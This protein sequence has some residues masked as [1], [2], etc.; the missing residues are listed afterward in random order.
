MT[1]AAKLDSVTV[2]WF[3]PGPTI[4][5]Y[6]ASTALVQAVMGP[7]GGGKTSS[8]FIKA[9]VLAQQQRRSTRDGVRRFKL[10]MVHKTYR[11]LWASIIPSWWKWM[12]KTAGEWTG[13]QDQPATHRINFALPDNTLV[14]L[15]VDFIA[16]GD[17]AA[18]DVLRGYEPTAFLLVEADL[19][20]REVLIYAIGR[21]GRFPSMNEGG[22]SWSGVLM[23]FNAPDT[24]S[25]LY[26]LLV[27]NLPEDWA[28]FRQPSAL[29]PQAENLENLPE[30]YY[31]RQIAGQPD[32]YVRRMIKNEFGYSRDGV[33]VYPEYNDALHFD[34]NLQIMPGL[35]LFLGAD[36]GG[37]PAV[38]V[39]QHAPDGQWR[40]LD[41]LT[42]AM[43]M[44]TG[45]TRFSDMV[46]RLLHE[47]YPKHEISG[48]VDPSAFYGGDKESKDDQAW[49]HIVS[50]R[51]KIRLRAAPTNNPTPRIE[52]LR[53]PMTRMIDG[54]K[55][56]LVVGPRMKV[57]RKG[58]L[59]G[60]RLRKILGP[61]GRYDDKPE[62]NEY[63]HVVEAGQYALLG[64]GEYNDVMNRGRRNDDG[65]RQVRAADEDYPD[66]VYAG[67]GRQSFA[68]DDDY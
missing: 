21:A 39:W 57:F 66:G 22:P 7:I 14:E 61:S 54:H 34:P 28:F 42:T 46:N 35:P 58:L 53:L 62:K 50:S 38:T 56:G 16:I 4:D 18:E 32:W 45:P 1:A 31:E 44:V 60:Y 30:G 27:E 17:N 12:P 65:R 3:S 41:E 20:D 24:E 63:S 26:E 8:G 48:H 55:P 19:L 11:R 29:S 15:T 37:T 23:D 5:R 13:A 25:Y 49:V 40:G 68:R 67:G 43:G 36:A 33:P 9:I 10:C 52:A 64:G 51:T 47:M 59:S 2:E 6:M